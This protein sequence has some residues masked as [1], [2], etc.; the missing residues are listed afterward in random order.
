[1]EQTMKLPQTS[2]GVTIVGTLKSKEFT[3]GADQNGK[4][5]MKGKL[6]VQVVDNEGISEIAINVKQNMMT[7]A[8]NENKL[9]KSLQTVQRDYITMDMVEAAKNQPVQEGQEPLVADLIRVNGEYEQFRFADEESGELVEITRIKG[10]FINR[11]DDRSTPHS[12]TVDIEGYL[13]NIRNLE[14]GTISFDLYPVNWAGTVSKYELKVTDPNLVPVFP[15]V[16]YEGCTAMMHANIVN[17]AIVENNGP[18]AFGAASKNVIT[19]YVRMIEVYGGQA[20]TQKL[21][22]TLAEQAI[23]ERKKEELVIQASAQQKKQGFPAGGDNNPNTF[24][25]SPSQEQNNN[26]FATGNPF[27]V[28]N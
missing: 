6:V 1:M 27:A 7:S 16:Y 12:A 26:P 24:G 14:D 21:D 2:N 3:T 28:T 23:E 10:T 15:T 13:K 20:P 9:Y 19:R 8:G 25:G 5:F 11:L 22:P 17:K 4:V 18:A